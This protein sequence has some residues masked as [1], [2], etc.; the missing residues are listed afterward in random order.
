M[1]MYL[2]G[3]WQQ[4]WF[5][6]DLAKDIESRGHIVTSRWLQPGHTDDRTRAAL[7]DLEDV[8]KADVLVSFTETPAVGYNTGG[9]HV[10]FGFAYKAGKLLVIIG[11][12]E[13]IFHDLPGVK[14]FD[15]YGAF[16]DWLAQQK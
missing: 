7:D 11:P 15:N 9:R 13:H 14:R 10:E 4:R 5:I 12:A 6:A 3:R 16:I 1:K 2:A 8:D